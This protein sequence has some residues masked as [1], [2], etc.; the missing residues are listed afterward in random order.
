M[1]A[2]K[3][4]KSTL[5]VFRTPLSLNSPSENHKA[6]DQEIDTLPPDLLRSEEIKTE[7]LRWTLGRDLENSLFL[8]VLPLSF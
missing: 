6:N 2:H 3:V 1:E 7:F 4:L 5:T 8:G